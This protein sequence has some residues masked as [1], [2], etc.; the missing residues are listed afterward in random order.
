MALVTLYDQES[1]VDKDNQS[2]NSPRNGRQVD[3]S[4]VGT[5]AVIAALVVSLFYA[6]HG[7]G[8]ASTVA[9]YFAAI[10]QGDSTLEGQTIRQSVQ[11]QSAVALRSQVLTMIGPPAEVRIGRSY[12]LGREAIVDVLFARP[13]YGVYAVKFYLEKPAIRWKIDAGRTWYSFRG[14]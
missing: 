9:R 10:S 14:N 5:A 13:D 4:S 3:P 2:S 8:A 11:N 1:S 7:Q 6:L 12:Q